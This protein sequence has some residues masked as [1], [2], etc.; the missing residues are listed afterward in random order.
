VHR[1][2]EV[3]PELAI[4]GWVNN[5]KVVSSHALCNQFASLKISVC[6]FVGQ[7]LLVSTV[8]DAPLAV[9]KSYVEKQKDFLGKDRMQCRKVYRCKLE[10]SARRHCQR[11]SIIRTAR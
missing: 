1:L 3:D 11:L 5:I 10:P 9:I 8:G 4:H 7:R 2:G 6:Y